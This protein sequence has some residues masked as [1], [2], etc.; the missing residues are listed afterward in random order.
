[1]RAQLLLLLVLPAFS[2]QL[3]IA[4]DTSDESKTIA[5]IELLGGKVERDDNLPGHPVVGVSLEGS[6]RFD[7]RY[8][9]LFTI[10]HSLQRLDLSDT[11]VTDAGLKTLP[12][13]GHLV[14]LNLF[15]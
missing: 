10:F 3:V 15:G 14:E 9:W 1:M 7:D 13:L 11:K 6:T 4:E 12:E 2:S 5:K 8:V